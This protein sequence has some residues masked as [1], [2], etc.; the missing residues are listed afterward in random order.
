MTPGSGATADS[1]TE[2]KILLIEKVLSTDFISVTTMKTV[3]DNYSLLNQSHQGKYLEKL[4]KFVKTEGNTAPENI[5]FFNSILK[6]AK[7]LNLS[8]EIKREI[9]EVLLQFIKTFSIN[10]ESLVIDSDFVLESEV[11]LTLNTFK[12]DFLVEYLNNMINKCDYKNS[13]QLV[14]ICRIFKITIEAKDTKDE[15][16]KSTKFIEKYLNFLRNIMNNELDVESDKL[17]VNMAIFETNNAMMKD[18]KIQLTI[19]QID[20]ML[21]FATNLRFIENLNDIQQFCKY[22]SVLGETLFI[23]AVVRQ[24]YFKDRSPHYFNIYKTF[25]ERIYFF[26]NGSADNFSPVEVSSLLKLTLQAEK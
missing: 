2:F 24:N 20:Q 18:N 6:D 15:D 8:D 25:V 4:L 7:K 12:N 19:A 5:R 26:K 23:V 17:T 13:L 1:I 3:K 9:V 21:N 22:M 16:K 10:N 11:L 14:H